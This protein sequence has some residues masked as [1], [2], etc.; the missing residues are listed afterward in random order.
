ATGSESMPL[1]G[2]EVDEKRIVSSTGALSLPK[3]PEHMVVVGG[4]Y[5]GLEMGSVWGRLGAKITVVEFRDRILPGMDSDGPGEMTKILGK[6]GM[7]FRLGTKVTG[8]KTGKSGVKL[9]VEPAKGGKAEEISC[10]VVLVAIG[11]RPYTEG[12]GLDELGIER[13]N[14]GF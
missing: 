12:L 9:A 3:V 10:D 5:I 11:R 1:P 2:V 13:D 8:A 6:Q 14:R 4:G 7:T